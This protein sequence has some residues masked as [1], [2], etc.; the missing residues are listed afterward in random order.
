[1]AQKISPLNIKTASA[2]KYA[3]TETVSKPFSDTPV[4]YRRKAHGL[5]PHTP[6]HSSKT[7]KLFA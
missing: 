5:I 3:D 6:F 4:R 7:L 1:M 2:L